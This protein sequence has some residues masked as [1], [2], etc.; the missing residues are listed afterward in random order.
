MKPP[1]V[2]PLG[3]P[4]SVRGKAAAKTAAAGGRFT[5]HL[6]AAPAGNA[7]A[8]AP[9]A[10]VFSVAALAALHALADDAGDGRRGH[11]RRR[12]EAL[13]DDLDRLR[14]DLLLGRV[15]ADRLARIVR[16][17]RDRADSSGDPALDQAIEAIEL[18]AEVELAKLER[19][20]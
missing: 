2:G 9:A 7:E 13:L 15:G 3:R 12:G 8:P 5:D 4:Q 11:A 14:T 10:E 1:V 6:A 16:L 19:H 18:R 17:L 20:R